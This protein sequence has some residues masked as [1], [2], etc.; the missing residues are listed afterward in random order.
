MMPET[1]NN[2]EDDIN[3]IHNADTP[4]SLSLINEI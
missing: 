1:I 4:A 3:S 2:I